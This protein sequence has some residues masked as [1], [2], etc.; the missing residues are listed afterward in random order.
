[1]ITVKKLYYF[2]E[3]NDGTRIDLDEQRYN[4]KIKEYEAL[5][6]DYDEYS[7]NFITTDS[8]TQYENCT[9]FYSNDF[10]VTIGYGQREILAR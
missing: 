9:N 1:M 8:Y 6:W 4:A 7:R 3:I 2:M 5:A 10:M